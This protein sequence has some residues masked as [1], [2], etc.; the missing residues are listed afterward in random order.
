M[1]N[2]Q[3]LDGPSSPS[4]WGDL[5]TQSI[6]CGEHKFLTCGP[7]ANWL[8]L[9]SFKGTRSNSGQSGWWIKQVGELQGINGGLTHIRNELFGVPITNIRIPLPVMAIS[10][11]TL[12]VF[13]GTERPKAQIR[14]WLWFFTVSQFLISEMLPVSGPPP[15]ELSWICVPLHYNVTFHI[16]KILRD[17]HIKETYTGNVSL[18]PPI[19]DATSELSESQNH[20]PV[21]T[22]CFLTGKLQK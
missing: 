10:L 6:F 22:F 4:F 18:I 9:A 16:G 5:H 12:S 1:F 8:L 13:W 11:F 20:F 14:F 15:W 7:F 2:I 17:S 19:L 3:L 21:I